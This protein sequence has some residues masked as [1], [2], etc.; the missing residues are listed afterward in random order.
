MRLGKFNFEMLVNFHF[1]DIESH[2][3]PTSGSFKKAVMS[4]KQTLGEYLESVNETQIKR[5]Q[6]DERTDEI[7][8]QILK[9][10]LFIVIAGLVVSTFWS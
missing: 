4:H 2:H 8:D 7:V 3:A 10:L 1:C 6:R 9:A 5:R